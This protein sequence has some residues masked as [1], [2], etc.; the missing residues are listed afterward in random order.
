MSSRL[1]KK[2]VWSNDYVEGVDEVMLVNDIDMNY[3]KMKELESWRE[4]KVYHEVP[5]TN[6]KCVSTRWVYSF[7]TVNNSL[8]PKARLVARGFE[9][10]SQVIQKDFP[11]CAHESHHKPPVEARVCSKLVWKLDKCLR[12]LSDAPLNWYCRVKSLLLELSFIKHLFLK[13][14]WPFLLSR[15]SWSSLWCIGMSC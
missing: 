8:V 12:G 11:T 15:W 14:I 9:E 7:K 4:N 13:L 6:Q 5:H 1:V 2:P 10:Y 3:A